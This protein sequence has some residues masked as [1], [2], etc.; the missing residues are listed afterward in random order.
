M[1]TLLALALL[2]CLVDSTHSVKCYS[3][4]NSEGKDEEG[5]ALEN[6]GTA[7]FK[8]DGHEQTDCPNGCLKVSA[9]GKQGK[10]IVRGCLES[11]DLAKTPSCAKRDSLTLRGRSVTEEACVCNTH[12][13]NGS[14]GSILFFTVPLF[15]ALFV[16]TI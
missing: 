14:P 11:S 5:N 2:V 6:Q 3:C 13:C 9:I 10:A 16:M 15:A 8:R 4:M 12:L 1:K 7:C